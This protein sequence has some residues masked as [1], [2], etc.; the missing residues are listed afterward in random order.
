MSKYFI[1]C[2]VCAIVTLPNI[3]FSQATTDFL[4]LSYS[5]IPNGEFKDRLVEAKLSHFDFNIITPTIKLSSKVKINNVLYYRFSQYNYSSFSD[6]QIQLPID[7][8]EIKYTMFARFTFNSNYEL[9]LVPKLSVRSD[10]NSSLNEKDMFPA[11][12]TILMK[13]SLKNDKMKWGFGLNYNNDLG[14]NSVIPIIAF[15]YL[16]DKMRFIAFFPNNA[17]LTFTSLKKIEYGLAFTTDATLIHV[18]TLDSIEYIRT[19]NV[20][21]NPTLSY[22]LASN[23]WL[24]LKAGV[25]MRRKYDLYNTDFETPSEDFENKLKSSGFLQLGVS[26]RSKS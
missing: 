6:Q 19:L 17:N 20:H 21:L 24:N 25:V 22:N 3:I 9:L 11:V 7:F 15:N 13:T 26:L 10:F 8:H 4:N 23:F 18:N 5:I 12:S 14:K 16:S 1:C 2:L